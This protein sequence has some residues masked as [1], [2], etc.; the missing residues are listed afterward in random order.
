MTSNSGASCDFAP[1]VLLLGRSAIS[2]VPI[3]EMER[4]RAGV[5]ALP[6]V[7]RAAFAFSEQGKPSLREAFDELIA[8]A[9]RRMLIIPLLL[10]AEPNFSTWLAKTL[11]RWQAADRRP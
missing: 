3:R 7:S 2:A 4:L 5:A 1:T 6:G 9:C 10:P 11:Q 8:A